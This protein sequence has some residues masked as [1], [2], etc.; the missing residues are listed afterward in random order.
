MSQQRNSKNHK[1]GDFGGNLT[2]SIHE[3]LTNRTGKKGENISEIVYTVTPEL[4]TTP[5]GF[6]NSDLR[7]PSNESITTS[8]REL[9][10]E[11]EVYVYHPPGN[12]PFPWWIPVGIILGLL[13]L[14]F[15]IIIFICIIRDQRHR[16]SKRI[17]NDPKRFKEHDY[18]HEHFTAEPAIQFD[19]EA[20]DKTDFYVVNAEGNGR[21]NV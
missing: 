19:N 13:L 14:I 18:D 17:D 21:S 8:L 3:V 6:T 10:P 12:D 16:A 9:H 20:F 15:I 5:R 11:L 4:G 2:V 1:F 7:V